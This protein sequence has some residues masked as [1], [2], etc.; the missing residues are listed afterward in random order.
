MG[1]EG[2]AGRIAPVRR[3]APILTRCIA[4]L[5]LCVAGLPPSSAAEP[6][7]TG[8][9]TVPGQQVQIVELKRDDA[10]LV[11][12]KFV[13]VNGGDGDIRFSDREFG[14]STKSDHNSVGGVHLIDAKNRKQY[15]VVR[16]ADGNCVCSRGLKTL[17]TGASANVWAKFPAPPDSVER[18]SVVVP[19]FMP[20]E[21]VPIS[22]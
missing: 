10:G 17:K 9:G 11:T 18:I 8:D 5:T 21:S 14:D 2:L 7:A 12:L 13:I 16:S 15:L 3:P 6:L 1:P 4:A 19:S 20:V 22:R